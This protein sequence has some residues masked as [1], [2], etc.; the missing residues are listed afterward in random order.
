M[1]KSGTR[2]TPQNRRGNGVK[3]LNGG[4]DPSIG[5]TTQFKSGESGN[6]GGRPK[7]KPVLEAIEAAILTDPSLIRQ[8][9]KK[10]L[11]EAARSLGWFTQVRDMLDGKPDGGEGTEVTSNVD[12]NLNVRF[13]PCK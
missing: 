9:A 6:A 2:S 4:V 5:K 12:F 13:V 3:L 1:K 10:A 7:R 8:I 11:T